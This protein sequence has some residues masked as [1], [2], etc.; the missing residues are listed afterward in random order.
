MSDDV[1]EE[2]GKL[3]RRMG[4]ALRRGDTVEYGSLSVRYARLKA[5][6]ME[7]AEREHRDRV[8]AR[9]AVR[10]AQRASEGPWRLPRGFASPLAVERA[11]TGVRPREEPPGA[12]YGLRPWRTEGP[13]ERQIW[14][15]GP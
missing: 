10:E 12:G 6:Q 11:R 8:R 1:T 9:R 15:P 4:R 3:R 2:L 7:D 14:R 5:Q 13:M